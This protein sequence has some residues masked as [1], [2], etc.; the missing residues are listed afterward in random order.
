MGFQSCGSPNLG[1]FGTPTWESRDKKNHLDVGLVERC[2]IYYKGE[3]GGFPQIRAMVSF[4]CPCYPWLILTPKVFQL[5]TNYLV[6]VLCRP[7]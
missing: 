2:K 7:V 4:V 3:G 1:D 5:R 6:W